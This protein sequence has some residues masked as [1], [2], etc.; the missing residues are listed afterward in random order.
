MRGD[1][2]RAEVRTRHLAFGLLFLSRGRVPVAINKLAIDG[3]DWNNR[4]R[5]VANLADW[6]T[7]QT[8]TELNWQIVPF[9][10]EP[11][12]WLDAPL[13][14]VAS[15]ERLPWL[16][17]LDVDPRR[18]KRDV[19]EFLRKRAAGEIPMDADPPVGPNV[20]EL[21]R[22]KRYLDLGGMLLAVNEGRTDAFADSVRVMGD[23]M[24]PQYDWM[25]VAPDHW[26]FT[27]HETIGSGRPPLFALSNGV[28]DLIVLVPGADLAASLQ[29]REHT[30]KRTHFET[31]TNLYFHA[32][33]MNRPRPRLE[34]H[35]LAASPHEAPESITVVRGVHG[36]NWK[37]EPQSLT[38]FESWFVRERRI[39]LRIIDHPLLAI[40]EL[41]P[42]PSLVLVSGIDAI[43]FTRPQLDAIKAYVNAGGFV[44]FETPGGVG[45]FAAAAEK[46]LNPS[47]ESPITALLRHPMVTGEGLDDAAELTRVAYRPYT[48]ELLKSRETTP[49]LRG[50]IIDGEPR[51]LFSREDITHGLLDQPCWGIS[52]YAPQDARNLL[53]N[54]AQYAAAHVEQS[55]RE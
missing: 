44:L 46:A 43:E 26:A 22:I 54:I 33:E 37:P 9:S 12:Q 36:G 16:D 14:Y 39:A 52:G 45:D 50:I 4:P 40:D 53:A 5:D 29:S 18:F 23:L 55:G 10:D 2:R 15:D 49:R 38:V 31:A 19:R 3:V 24:Y 32:S 48:F 30:R 47:F 34:Q 42:R 6:I 25:R 35:V 7:S 13:L 11:E 41:Q 20:P 17:G 28:R 51:V 8:E 1:G 21:R 27:I